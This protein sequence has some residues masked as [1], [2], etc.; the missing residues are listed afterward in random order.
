MFLLV[1]RQSLTISTEAKG[2]NYMYIKLSYNGSIVSTSANPS[3][4]ISGNL[5][6]DSYNELV[7]EVP[8][9][10]ISYYDYDNPSY[11]RGKI[12]Y[13][14][15]C[16]ISYY[17]DDNESCKVGKVRYIGDTFVS[18]YDSDYGSYCIGKV[19]YVDNTLITYYDDDYESYKVGKVRYVGDTFI[20][21]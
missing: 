4:R 6:L 8:D 21:A 20:S 3:R 12:R 2:I 9:G 10:S 16:F 13:I 7:I 19:R 18:Y 1:A 5:Y 14:G 11:C 15:N 17:D